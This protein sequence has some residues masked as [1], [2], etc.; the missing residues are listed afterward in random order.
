VTALS[1]APAHADDSLSE[2]ADGIKFSGHVDAGASF[3]AASKSGSELIG[4]ATND[5]ANQLMLNQ[6][7][8]TVE[9]P[10][11]SKASGY[12]FG[13]RLQGLF[14][15]DARLT[16]GFAEMDHMIDAREQLDVT[17]AS[18]SA[19]LPVLT[20]GGLDLKVGQ[21]ATP[22]GAE[23]IDAT[24]NYLYSHSY[25]YNYGIP[26]KQT[27]FL[28]TAHVNPLLDLYAGMD[29]GVNAFVGDGGYNNNAAKGQFGFGLNMLDGNLT[30][31]GFSHIGAETPPVMGTSNNTLRYLNDITTTWK[32]NDD[33]TLINDANYIA[34]DGTRAIGY[35]MAQYAVL[36]LNDQWSLVGRAEVW[37]DNSG[38]YVAGFPGNFDYVNAE[39]G[40]P[41]PGVIPMPHATYSEITIGANYKPVVPKAIEGFMI[42]PE[43]RL[44][45][46]LSNTAVFD[47]NSAGVPQDRNSMTMAVDF[48][49]PF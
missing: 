22:M 25:I 5:K 47:I 44:D 32:V 2:W 36:A 28:V 49:L 15:T 43:L 42:R 20:E 13:F 3:N 30:V 10:I 31:L 24:G 46:A 4:N 34:D 8:A 19:H 27:G 48:V 38:F 14:G 45:H 21:F 29:T 12:D 23:V 18:I 6:V 17:E 7:M 41:A 35:G 26:L 40:L 33:W 39:R 1:V 9:R 11:D 37:R 16:H